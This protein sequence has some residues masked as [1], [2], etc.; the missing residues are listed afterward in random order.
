M[1][2]GAL[3]LLSAPSGA[4]KTTLVN[5]V[6][7]TDSKL[8]VSVS[9]TTRSKRANEIDGI[10]YHFVSA[11]QFDAMV[12]AGEFLEHAEVFKHQYGTALAQVARLREQ[13]LDV[14][15]EIDWQGADQVR[16]QQPD[17]ISIFVLPPSIDILRER[18]AARGQDSA[19]SM[20]IRL[21]EAQ[22]DISQASRYQYILVNDDFDQ[23]LSDL[24]AVISAGRLRA[25]TQIQGNPA[26]KAILSAS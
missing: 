25:Q 13:G 4:G 1:T 26:V 17:A 21:A 22:L 14:V 23:A 24:T 8:I 10:N 20:Q 18:L 2:T 5:A 11:E 7:Q 12:A 9:H 6:L 15:L 16:R 19:E 3:I